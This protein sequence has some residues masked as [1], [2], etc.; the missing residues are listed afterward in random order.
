MNTIATVAAAA[1]CEGAYAVET[2]P[3]DQDTWTSLVER[4]DDAVLMQTWTYGAVRW[5]EDN[6]SRVV[7]KRDG[8][9]VSVAQSV[10]VKVPF[11]GACMA[12]VKWGPLWRIRGKEIDIEV[13]RQMIRALRETYAVRRRLLLRIF[14]NSTEDETGDLRS[15]L[16]EEGFLHD[17]IGPNRTLII[18]LSYSSGELRES[19]KGAWRRNLN[20]AGKAGMTVV[21]GVGDD[22]F[23]V[24]ASLYKQMQARKRRSEIADIDYFRDIQKNLPDAFKLQIMICQHEGEPIAGIA[25]SRMGNTAVNLLAATGDKGLKMRGSY[26]LH[27]QM[28]ERLQMRGC[29][30]YDLFAINPETHPGTTQFKSGFAGKLGKDAA[31]L[32]QFSSCESRLKLLTIYFAEKLRNVLRRS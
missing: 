8:E 9:V 1:R 7:L 21:E 5:R 26:L 30:W 22:L 20:I 16:K 19:L 23:D 18:D 32:G 17:D 11:L 6:L 15:I 4:F 10:I 13:F 27:W 31:Y 12:Y 14:F 3:I 29:R 2:G 28:L 25:V 24:L